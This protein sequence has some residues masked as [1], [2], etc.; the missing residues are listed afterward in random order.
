[1]A[2]EL[3]EEKRQQSVLSL[4][5]AILLLLLDYIFVFYL[6]YLELFCKLQYLMLFY[7]ILRYSLVQNSYFMETSSSEYQLVISYLK[8]L[9][10]FA[11]F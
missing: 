11:K 9:I 7:V 1:M 8:L 3:K 5:L 10:C 6:I 4:R 2:H